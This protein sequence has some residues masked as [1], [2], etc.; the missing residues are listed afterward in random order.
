MSLITGTA[1]DTVALAGRVNFAEIPLAGARNIPPPVEGPGL[2]HRYGSR[3]LCVDERGGRRCRTGW[4]PPSARP[5]ASLRLLQLGVVQQLRRPV[6]LAPLILVIALD[7]DAPVARGDARGHRLLPGVRRD[8]AGLG[9]RLRP[10][11][12]GPHDPAGA[13][14]SPRAAGLASAAAPGPHLAALRPGHHGRLLRRG[15]ARSPDVRRRHGP[16]R[17]GGRRR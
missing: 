14:C 1:L 2:P 9:R 17:S 6:P 12:P 10:A 16:A 15:G 3:A 4:G 7:L 11:R 8:A 5:R 13:R